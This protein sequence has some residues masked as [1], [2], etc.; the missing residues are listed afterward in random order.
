[1][2]D[3][4]NLKEEAKRFVK[5]NK[6]FFDRFSRDIDDLTIGN[7][8]DLYIGSK[9][10]S[11]LNI[12]SEFDS[13]Y[14]NALKSFFEDKQRLSDVE[15]VFIGFLDFLIWL[16]QQQE[17]L[18]VQITERKQLHKNALE[19]S[20]TINRIFINQQLHD[21][22]KFEVLL[23]YY[24]SLQEIFKNVVQEE[25]LLNIWKQDKTDVCELRKKYLQLGDFK[26][27]IEKYEKQKKTNNKIS[28]IFDVELRNK[29][30]HADY[31]IEDENIKYGSKSLK[32][33][34]AFDMIF[35]LGIILQFF[36]LFYLRLFKETKQGIN[37]Q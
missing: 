23:F 20:K 22:D 7:Y 29:I 32:K 12:G 33:K 18:V 8:I 27:I 36:V 16:K 37:K 35:K 11:S 19:Y 30:L 1:M 31:L 26:S 13:D 6:I 25:L 34:D 17:I 24:C 2:S 15:E 9:G 21:S 4:D 14:D 28:N 10:I 5:E 3:F